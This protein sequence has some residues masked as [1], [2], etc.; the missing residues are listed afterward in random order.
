M[1]SLANGNPELMRQVKNT[2]ETQRKGGNRGPYDEDALNASAYFIPLS[3]K[4]VR[5]DQK[6]A[7]I[8]AKCRTSSADA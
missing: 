4:G 5:L 3:F 8:N 7:G 1:S 6:R 2:F